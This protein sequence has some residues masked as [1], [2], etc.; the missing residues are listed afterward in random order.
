MQLVRADAFLARTD[1]MHCGQPIAHSNVAILEN[2]PDLHGERLAASVAFVEANPITFA[3][4]R[5]GTLE[6]AT[7]RTNA[8]SCPN[9]RLDIG[10][11]SCF[12]VEMM[13]GKDGP[14]HG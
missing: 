7:M 4:K 2:C 14:R 5:R 1:K 3:F 13:G 6:H 10:V 12:V 9:A 8:A 11:S